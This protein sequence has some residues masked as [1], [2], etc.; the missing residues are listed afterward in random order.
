MSFFFFFYAALMLPEK[1]VPFNLVSTNLPL[2]LS[3]L[4]SNSHILQFTFIWTLEKVSKNE[5]ERERVC[6]CM[7]KRERVRGRMKVSAC[8]CMCVCVWERERESYV[9]LSGLKNWWIENTFSSPHI[10]PMPSSHPEP[11]LDL[12]NFYLY[13]FSTIIL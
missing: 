1:R 11:F 5:R 8:V 7:C 13:F 9:F 12:K 10:R 6:V 4:N 2:L 3:P